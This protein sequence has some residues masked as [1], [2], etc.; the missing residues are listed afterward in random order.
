MSYVL[1]ALRMGRTTDDLHRRLLLLPGAVF[2][3]VCIYTSLGRTEAV[4]IVKNQTWVSVGAS[5]P[6]PWL[7]KGGS[8]AVGSARAIAVREA[9]ELGVPGPGRAGRALAVPGAGPCLAGLGIRVLPPHRL[10][11][12]QRS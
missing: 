6:R 7:T 11:R 3:C 1:Q 12:P 4:C 8:R 2:I 5:P 9:G 10:H